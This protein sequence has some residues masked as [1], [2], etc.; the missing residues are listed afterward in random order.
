ME[1]RQRNRVNVLSILIRQV[2]TTIND[3]KRDTDFSYSTIGNIVNDLQKK[4]LISEG[5]KAPSTGGRKPKIITLNYQ[6]YLF[7]SI[8]LS[9]HNFHWAVHDLRGV[10]IY[11]HYYKYDYSSSFQRN[12]EN[13]VEEI[14]THCRK[15]RIN[16]SKLNFLG[17]GTPGYYKEEEGRVF[18]SS[19]EEIESIRIND[20]LSEKFELPIIIKNDANIAAYSEIS[21]FHYQES[22]CLVYFLITREGVGSAII[23][24]GEVFPGARG[25][26]GETHE[27]LIEYKGKITTMGDLLSPEDDKKYLSSRLGIEIDDETFFKLFEEKNPYALELYEKTIQALSC[28]FQ[29]IINL[30]NPSDIIISGFYNAYGEQMGEEIMKI[31]EKRMNPHQIEG[32]KIS[33]SHFSDKTILIGLGKWMINQWC[34]NI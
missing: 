11:D 24:G 7:L 6:K 18:H 20:F 25:Y 32:L 28:G 31:L 2:E 10:I 15:K 3:L 33:F 1:L 19:Y 5:R 34:S 21:S 22:K 14:K 26:A 23:L 27:I 16:M 12:L 8:D 30:L 9:S 13:L 4:G 17:L 29:Q